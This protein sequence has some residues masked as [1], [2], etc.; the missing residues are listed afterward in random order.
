MSSKDLVTTS[1]L[2]G[3][4]SDTKTHPEAIPAGK[5]WLV[6]WLR[7]TGI[8]LGDLKSSVF[9]L[10]FGTDI[11]DIVSVLGHTVTA[12]ISMEL[13]GDGVKKLSLQRFNFSSD[14]KQLP[15]RLRISPRN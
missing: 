11:V 9:I 5:K 2:A 14:T 12:D 4:G 13:T 1:S 10:R 15:A 8:C 3:G 7:A 6:R